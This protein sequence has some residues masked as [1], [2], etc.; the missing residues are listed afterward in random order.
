MNDFRGA[1]VEGYRSYLKELTQWVN[2]K[3]NLQMS[4]QVSYNLPMDMEANI[5]YVN[6]PE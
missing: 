5:P 2:S 4:A 1:L 3:L 6:A